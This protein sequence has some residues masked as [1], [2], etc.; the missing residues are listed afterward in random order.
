MNFISFLTPKDA[1]GG[2]TQSAHRPGDY[3]PF[4][5]GTT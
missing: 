3:L 5:T 2:G 4:H 1:E